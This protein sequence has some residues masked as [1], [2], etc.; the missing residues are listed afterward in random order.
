LENASLEQL[1]TWAIEAMKK[2]QDVEI[3]P[4]NIAISV[5]GKNQQFRILSTEEVEPYIRVNSS[6]ME[7]V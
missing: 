1:I 5:V 7:V 3:T 4:Y 2:S 6:G